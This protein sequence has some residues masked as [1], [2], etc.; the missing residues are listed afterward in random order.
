MAVR[1]ERCDRRGPLEAVA[2]RVLPRKLALP[3]VGH[4]TAVR[5]QLVAPCVVGAVEPAACGKLPFGFGRELLSGPLG[6][7][8]RVFVAGLPG[9]PGDV[10]LVKAILAMAK[11]LELK[12]VAE[13]VEN[14]EQLSFLTSLGCDLAQGYLLARPIDEVAYSAYLRKLPVAPTQLLRLAQNRDQRAISGSS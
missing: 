4:V 7:G 3:G 10:S 12:V 6:V 9:N 13:G 5:R 1:R 14:H 11:G 2:V 8:K